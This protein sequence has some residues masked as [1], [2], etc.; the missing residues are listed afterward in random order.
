MMAAQCRTSWRKYQFFTGIA[1][2][3]DVSTLIGGRGVDWVNV[4]RDMDKWWVL[5]IT[6]LTLQ[7]P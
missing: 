7:F 6:V 4:A 3:E 2:T 1:A 5:V